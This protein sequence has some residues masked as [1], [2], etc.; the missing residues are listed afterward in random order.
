MSF[1]QHLADSY[2]Q[3]AEALNKTHP[4]STTSISNN[5][6]IIA[7]IVIDGDGNFVRSDKFDN[8]F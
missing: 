7:I 5:G 2:D 3:N 1:W 8:C 4:L 6:D